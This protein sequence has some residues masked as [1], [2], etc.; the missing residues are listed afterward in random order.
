MS[1][2]EYTANTVRA[3]MAAEIAMGSVNARFR[4]VTSGMPNDCS[5]TTFLSSNRQSLG[6]PITPWTADPDAPSTIRYAAQEA[7]F[8]CRHPGVDQANATLLTWAGLPPAGSHQLTAGA[9]YSI[10]SSARASSEGGTVRPSAFAVLRLITSSN[11]V[12]A[13]TGSSPGLAP[14]RMR[15]T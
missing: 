14:R 7:G 8:R 6:T 15:S 9:L 12:G 4:F 10:T 3:L 5:T 1:I 2:T 11:L 13:C